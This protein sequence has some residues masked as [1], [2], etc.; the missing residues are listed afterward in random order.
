MH[1]VLLCCRKWKEK[2]DPSF[3]EVALY[4]GNIKNAKQL[5]MEVWRCLLSPAPCIAKACLL[6]ESDHRL[7]LYGS[8]ND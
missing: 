1:Q 7:V 5:E 8:A 3:D 4:R 6:M 2:F